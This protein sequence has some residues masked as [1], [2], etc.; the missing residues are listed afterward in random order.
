[1]SRYTQAQYDAL[2]EAVARGVTRVSYNGQTVEYRDLA[3]MNQLLLRMESDL[4][5]SEPRASRT[6]YA[7]DC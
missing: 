2:R 6:R 7:R 1:M 5:L 3:E 4:G